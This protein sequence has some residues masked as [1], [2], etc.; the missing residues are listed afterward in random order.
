M[1]LKQCLGREK[2]QRPLEERKGSWSFDIDMKYRVESS[3]LWA[4]HCARH[5]SLREAQHSS[6]PRNFA[7]HMGR[8]DIFIPSGFCGY[9]GLVWLICLM[10]KHCG[11]ES[12]K[13]RF[14]P[15]HSQNNFRTISSKILKARRYQKSSS[16]LL[17][18]VQYASQVP[19]HINCFEYSGAMCSFLHIH[20]SGSYFVP[21]TVLRRPLTCKDTMPAPDD[22]KAI[23]I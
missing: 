10:V 14:N 2:K 22:I 8:L 15:R 13:S 11:W 4:Q 3:P 6:V 23:P 18:I 19:V 20:V 17:L 9:F 7:L 12:E 1:G 16:P 21:C 5:R